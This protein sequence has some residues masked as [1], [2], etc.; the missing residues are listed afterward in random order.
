MVKYDLK[1]YN[2]IA[3]MCQIE[4]LSTTTIK[5]VND[6]ARKVGAPNYSKTPIFKKKPRQH[7]YHINKEDWEQIRNFK[8]TQLK[9]NQ[10]GI[11]AKMDL[12][13]INLNKLTKNNY[14]II[15]N[16]IFN[17]I[18]NIIDKEKDNEKTYNTLL[19]IG[20]SIFEIG[21]LNVFW[22]AMY[23]KLFRD[24]IENFNIMEKVCHENIAK[25]LIIFDK[26]DCVKLTNDN[27]SD[28]CN[29]NK[30]NENRRGMSS[31]FANLM[32]NEIVT[33]T[34]IYNVLSNLLDKI[35]SNSSNVELINVNEEIMENISIIL[36]K[37]KDELKKEEKEWEGIVRTIEFYS[38]Q[39]TEEGISK[40]LQFKCLDIIDELEE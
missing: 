23:A 6:L 10:D 2:K 16:E 5:I 18:N 28:F 31:F 12:L 39:N 36:I 3:E 8:T 30:K 29:C 7:K 4:E 40:K 35:N 9:K 22:S 1:D 34:Y 11:E 37:G 17:F 33:K 25:F 15:S 19:E 21:C 38:E 20:Y 26:I 27:Y 14:D 32:L 13:R 24:L